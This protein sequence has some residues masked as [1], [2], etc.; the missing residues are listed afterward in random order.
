[1]I[2]KLLQEAAEE[3]NQEAFCNQ[4]IGESKKSQADKKE[5]TR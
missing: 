1:M 5:E 4:E 2:A 3:D